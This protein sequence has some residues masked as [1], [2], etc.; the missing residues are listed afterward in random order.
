MGYA[1]ALKYV[2]T[3]LKGVFPHPGPLLSLVVEPVNSSERV[4]LVNFSKLGQM[5]RESV[6]LPLKDPSRTGDLTTNADPAKEKAAEAARAMDLFRAAYVKHYFEGKI[7]LMG[8]IDTNNP[9]EYDSSDKFTTPAGR[10]EPGVLYHASAAY[11]F[12]FEPIYE[13]RE[14]VRVILEIVLGGVFLFAVWIQTRPRPQSKGFKS[15]LI[16]LA[17]QYALI[18]AALLLVSIALIAIKHFRILWLDATWV[19]LGLLIHAALPPY[20]KEIARETR[21]GHEDAS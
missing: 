14:W 9:R 12:G 7:V 1:L 17:E 5:S 10:E 3:H 16:R 20:V 8:D 15:K 18:V 11:T 2:A 19:A 4:Q 21:G 13:F 6:W